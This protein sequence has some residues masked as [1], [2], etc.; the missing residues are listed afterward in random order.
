M[1]GPFVGPIEHNKFFTP[2][3]PPKP[4]FWGLRNVFS[5]GGSAKWYDNT[6]WPISEIYG[7]NHSTSRQISAE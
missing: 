1:L 3:L 4:Q 7:S 5:M 2:I 6:G